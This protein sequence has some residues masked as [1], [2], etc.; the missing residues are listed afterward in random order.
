MNRMR[1]PKVDSA[2]LDQVCALLLEGGLP[3]MQALTLRSQLQTGELRA[4]LARSPEGAAT[5]VVNER[6]TWRQV[7]AAHG[8][9]SA[10]LLGVAELRAASDGLIWDEGALGIAAEKLDALGFRLLL[11]QVFTQELARVPAADPLPDDLE[12]LPLGPQ[13]LA[14]ARSLF[15]RTH[16][17][18]VEGLYATLP[19]APSVARCEAAF[20]EY[21]SGQH[22]APVAPACVVVRIGQKVVGVICCAATETE[23]TG[24]LLGLAVDPTVRGRGLSRVLVRRAQHA[25]QASGFQRMLF[26]TTDRNAPVHRLFTLDEIIETETFPTRIWFREMPEQSKRAK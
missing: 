11:R 24:I 2:H 22:G 3:V 20:D 4:V 15:A 9:E 10:L 6:G 5:A 13:T 19:D 21:L 23:G 12:V 16:A 8:P 1:P 14:E 26:L 25:L 18:S 7:V 17:M